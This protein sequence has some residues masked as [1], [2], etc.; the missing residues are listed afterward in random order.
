MKKKQK[1]QIFKLEERVLFDGAA[2]AEIVAAVNNAG[3]AGNAEQNADDSEPGKEEKFVQNTVRNAGPVDTPAPDANVQNAGE[4]LPQADAA[5]NDPADVLIQGHADFS[6]LT[7]PDAGFSG[8]VADFIQAASHPDSDASAHEL[9]VIDSDAADRID[10]A[11]FEGKNVLVLDAGSDAADQIDEWMNEHSDQNINEVRLVTDSDTL[12]SQV[13]DI[14]NLE[15]TAVDAFQSELADADSG[16]LVIVPD[17]EACITVDASADELPEALADDAGEGRHE[18]VI[19]NSTMAD[20]DNVLDQLGDSRDILIIDVKSDAFEQISDYLNNSDAAYDAVHILTHGN[21]GGVVLG[22]QFVSDADSFAVFADHITADGDILFYGCDMAATESGQHF[23]QNIADVTGADV[24]ASADITG[25]LAHNGNWTLEYSTGAIETTAVTLDSSWNHRL[26]AYTIGTGGTYASLADLNGT[27][28]LDG[29]SI[30]YLESMSD[31][32]T[33]SSFTINGKVT[34]ATGAFEVTVTGGT[35]DF[36]SGQLIVGGTGTLTLQ[37]VTVTGDYSAVSAANILNVIEKTDSGTLNIIGGSM[38]VTGAANRAT[39]LIANT[40]GS[41]V[42]NISGE[43][44]ITLTSDIAASAVIYNVK[45]HTVTIGTDGTAD[46]TKISMTTGSGYEVYG[47]YNNGTLRICNSFVTAGGTGSVGLF[48]GTDGT[49]TFKADVTPDQYLTSADLAS[50]SAANLVGNFSKL[51]YSITG[52]A[53]S[54]YNQK[55][56]TASAPELKFTGTIDGTD[57]VRH[58]PGCVMM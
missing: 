29:D 3:N 42:I 20:L 34:L 44:Q 31:Y 17:P 16:N 21:D 36:T 55:S 49:V 39:H 33:G 37:D 41:G 10:D 26:A 1:V 7:D 52:G 19:V 50:L 54:V 30:A 27:T 23:I 22:S 28:F 12:A 9:I 18:L 32:I 48:N 46:G 5:Q 35:F 25:S 15:V 38:T 51:V 8:D 2:A 14:D 58:V 13:S 43:A 4:S 45:D 11:A 57:M 53:Y 40:A 56:F 6:Q 47:I 24:A